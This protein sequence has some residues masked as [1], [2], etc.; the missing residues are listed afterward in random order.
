MVLTADQLYFQ[1]VLIVAFTVVS[2]LHN[3]RDERKSTIE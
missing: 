1:M 2:W 3:P